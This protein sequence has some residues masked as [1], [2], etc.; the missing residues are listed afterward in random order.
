MTATDLIGK[1]LTDTSALFQTNGVARGDLVRNATDSSWATVVSVTSETQ[2]V[3]QRLLGG[4]GNTY[5]SS[6]VYEIFGTEQ[7]Q[8][9]G[10]NLLVV[11]EADSPI[12]AL[13]PTFGT[14]VTRN[15]S[16]DGVLI[17]QEQV[18][19]RVTQ[20]WQ[21]RGFDAD[22]PLT[23]DESRGDYFCGWHCPHLGWCGN[24]DAH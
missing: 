7:C 16:T 21:D 4:S 14:A 22:N 17:G 1:Y 10:G 20:L 9:T 19:T 18:D 5:D 13:F 24:Q 8:I 3:T 12:D 2:L 11:D 23:V 15:Q 6:D